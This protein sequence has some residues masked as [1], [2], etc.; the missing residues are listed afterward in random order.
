MNQT[1]KQ[2][3]IIKNEILLNALD[4]IKGGLICEYIS[5]NKNKEIE[6]LIG[7]MKDLTDKIRTNG[8]DCVDDL[9]KKVEYYKKIT[10]KYLQ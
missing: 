4:D 6:D 1:Q 10:A 8:S 2:N 3:K 9:E 7:E 5:G